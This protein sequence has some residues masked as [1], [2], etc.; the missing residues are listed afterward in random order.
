MQLSAGQFEA[1]LL[2]ENRLGLPPTFYFQLVDIKDDWAFILK[3]HSLFEGALHRLIAQKIRQRNLTESMSPYDSFY[4]RVM[5]AKK[6]QLLE[7]ESKT[8]LLALNHLRNCLT[9]DIRF[10]N[11]K[12]SKYF[13]LLSEREFRMS[14]QQL[15]ISFQNK[16]LDSQE[17]RELV[18]SQVI[19]KA[20]KK[21][22][23]RCEPKT[24]RELF[25]SI[26]P[27]AMI[28]SGG[29]QVLDLVSLHFHH[30][31]ISGSVEQEPKIWANLQDLLLDPNV[32]AYKKKLSKDMGT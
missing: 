26:S 11:V 22:T 5:L 19:S 24:L 21:H 16:A 1:I 17:C 8:Y 6:L 31:V 15:A 9:H 4:S 14:A 10:I 3:L 18:S 27:K 25:F 32:I 12:L 30:E 23:P 2:A 20:L 7:P 29:I 13:D 28:W